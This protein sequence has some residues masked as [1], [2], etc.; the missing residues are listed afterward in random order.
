MRQYRGQRIDSG[1]WIKGSLVS[2]DKNRCFIVTSLFQNVDNPS[3]IYEALAYKVHPSTVGQSTGLKDLAKKE[4]FCGDRV[5][6]IDGDI[7][8]IIW[9]ELDAM[10]ALMNI[11][12]PGSQLKME[13]LQYME[14]IGTIHKEQE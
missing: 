11:E 14:I 3:N 8:K 4:G 10:F 6:D 13:A 12:N 5:K 2:D 1:K 9:R 7:Y